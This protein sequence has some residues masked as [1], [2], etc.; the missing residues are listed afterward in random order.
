LVC[1][2]AIETAP[3]ADMRSTRQQGSAIGLEGMPYSGHDR[4]K[5]N[6]DRLPDFF[7]P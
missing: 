3:A 5:G 1:T 7:E 6:T 2:L 4:T